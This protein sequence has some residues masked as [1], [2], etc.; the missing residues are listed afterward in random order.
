MVRTPQLVALL[1]AFVL[2]D[3]LEVPATLVLLDMLAQVPPALL[4]AP[5]APQ[6]RSAVLHVPVPKVTLVLLVTH[7][8][9]ASTK[10]VS[11]VSPVDL[12]VL[13]QR[14]AVQHVHVTRVSSLFLVHRAAHAK[15]GTT[16]LALKRT[17]VLNAIAAVLTA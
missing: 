16:N 3:T 2:R 5:M 13:V 11:L 9:R 14:L 10:V 17:M 15:T 7:A 6:L 1:A 8:W 12:T 4:V